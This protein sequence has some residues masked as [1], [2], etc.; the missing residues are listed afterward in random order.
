MNKNALVIFTFVISGLSLLTCSSTV[1]VMYNSHYVNY[2][3]PG[4]SFQKNSTSD[5]EITIN[6]SSYKPG[7]Y[8]VVISDEKMENIIITIKMIKI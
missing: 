5:D 4:V 3:Y 6:V 2:G 8:F 7:I 1:A